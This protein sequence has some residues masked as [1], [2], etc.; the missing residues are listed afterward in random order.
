MTEESGRS[1]DPEAAPGS[2]RYEQYWK[3]TKTGS[4]FSSRP[5][6]IDGLQQKEARIELAPRIRF[7]NGRASDDSYRAVETAATQLV[8]ALTL[9]QLVIAAVA[10]QVHMRKAKEHLERKRRLQERWTLL[11]R[12]MRRIRIERDTLDH[13]AA[14]LE[15]R[16][17]AARDSDVPAPGL[18]ALFEAE[19]KELAERRAAGDEEQAGAKTEWAEL[20]GLD[21]ELLAQAPHF[22]QT[23]DLGYP[24]ILLLVAPQGGSRRRS[25]ASAMYALIEALQKPLSRTDQMLLEIAF[26]RC[27]QAYAPN[28]ERKDTSGFERKLIRAAEKEFAAEFDWARAY[29]SEASRG[30]MPAFA[31]PPQPLA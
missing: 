1:E 21:A 17:A 16:R 14:G 24:M 4:R 15:E 11:A 31:A 28:G 13:A 19:G 20:E 3:L 30:E 29:V 26:R 23:E 7:V 8:K 9:D 5:I 25:T 27:I 2:A 6:V 12:H 18:E 22:E 10:L